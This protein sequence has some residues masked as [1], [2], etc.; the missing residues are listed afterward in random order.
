MLMKRKAGEVNDL[1]GKTWGRNVDVEQRVA[2]GFG[3]S[4]IY[5]KIV[6][7]NGLFGRQR[8]GSGVKAQAV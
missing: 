2:V 1:H 4:V 3:S 8:P 7:K 6:D 5:W